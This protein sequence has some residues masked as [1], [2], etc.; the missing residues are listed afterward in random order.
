M[1][2]KDYISMMMGDAADVGTS[3]TD[4]TDRTDNSN[5]MGARSA[6]PE[7]AFDAYGARF[8]HGF[9]CVRVSAIGLWCGARFST[10]I[11][12]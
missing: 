2:A 3:S 12:T 11:Y 7:Y 8:H 10:G 4:G 9:C 1:A 5:S 6:M